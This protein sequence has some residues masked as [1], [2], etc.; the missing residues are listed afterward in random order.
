MFRAGQGLKWWLLLWECILSKWHFISVHHPSSYNCSYWLPQIPFGSHDSVIQLI[1][2][3]P[4]NRPF[5]LFPFSCVIVNVFLVQKHQEMKA[6]QAKCNVYWLLGPFP[7]FFLECSQNLS[8]RGKYIYLVYEVQRKASHCGKPPHGTTAT[9]CTTP[10]NTRSS[11]QSSCLLLS[12]NNLQ[13][14]HYLRN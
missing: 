12:C 2:I 10:G 9:V 1:K 5:C 14:Q 11:I 4:K 8:C 13:G 7:L 6:C 3:P